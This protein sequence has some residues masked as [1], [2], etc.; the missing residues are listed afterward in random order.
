MI[1]RRSGAIWYYCKKARF[2]RGHMRRRHFIVLL[3]GA[4][5]AWPL[6]ARG[7]ETGRTRR[8][9][10]LMGYA[11]NDPEAHIRLSAFKQILLALG[12]NEGRNLRI[13]LRWAASGDIDRAS[14]FAKDLVAQ[15]PDVILSNT[16]Q[17]TV[18]LYREAHTIPIVF[19]PVTDP[20]GEG[21]VQSLPRPGGNIT[22]HQF[23][24]GNRRQMA[25][26]AERDRTRTN[27]G[28][29]DIQSRHGA[30]RRKLSATV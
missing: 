10:V 11:E 17:S 15:Q 5:A 25:G 23:R 3:G 1:T 4:A 29:S 8:I 16:T 21:F 22:F 24:T 2:L 9:G 26:S 12:W 30:T 19:A 20:I 14:K 28:C 27:A 7:Q 13:A 18:A 6:I